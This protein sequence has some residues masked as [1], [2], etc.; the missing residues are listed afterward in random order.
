MKTIVLG[1]AII[2]SLIAV[3]VADAS[4]QAVQPSKKSADNKASDDFKPVGAKVGSFTLF[5][6][7]N[8]TQVYDDNFYKKKTNAT[9]I[10][11]TTIKPSVSL[12]SDWGTH[13]LRFDGNVERGQHWGHEDDNYW[14]GDARLRSQIDVSKATKIRLEGRH[15]ELS[16]ARGGDDSA[17]DAAEP[18]A[19]DRQT[20]SVS[21]N[22]KPNR[23]SINVGI[24]GNR[25]NYDDN[26]NIDGSTTNNDDRD[27]NDYK[28]S[29]RLGY[30]IQEGYEAFVRGE[31]GAVNYSDATDDNGQNRDSDGYKVEA[32]LALQLTNLVRGDVGVG[33]L[34]KQMD[35]TAF[36]DVSGYSANGN[37]TWTFTDLT[38]VRFSL[39]R[40][41]S[42]T[43]TSGASSNLVTSYGIG[44][45]HEF[46][47]NL[48]AK[49]DL[50]Y[51]T[52]DFESSSDN[53]SDDKLTASAG[54]NYEINRNLYSG[55]KYSY[56]NR[57]S[58]ID[59]NDYSRNIFT[60]NVGLRF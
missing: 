15:R 4:A 11:Y 10:H 19:L 26:A 3:S 58:N 7:L 32:G 12:R 33:W 50:G 27:R 55:V 46:L 54:L 47:R 22:H 34:S 13:S 21:V 2:V 53:R 56:E 57:D 20:V 31:Y 35:D 5:P 49:A 1:G 60:A 43:T 25:Y 41:L 59:T 52:T 8:V 24:E 17:T 42:E 37:L 23:I 29:G 28:A 9:V 38:K 18:T 16:E 30:E 44:L 14:T 48:T 36:Q 45:D 51:S 6:D 40:S 39:G